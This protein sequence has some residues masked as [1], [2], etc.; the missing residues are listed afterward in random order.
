MARERTFSIIKPDATRRNLTGAINA[1][2][3]AAGLRIVAQKRVHMTKG[4]AET[5]YAGCSLDIQEGG[6]H[7]YQG[8]A[9]RIPEILTLAGFDLGL[10]LLQARLDGVALVR[11]QHADLGQHGRVGDRAHDVM[12]VQTLVEVDRGGEAGD[13]G[14]DGLAEAAA[15]GLVGFLAAHAGL[16]QLRPEKVARS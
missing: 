1:K 15:P 2:I 8:F 9:R 5:F 6:D 4:Q 13:E 3:E 16:V 11:G 10:D 14:V 7:S 12:A